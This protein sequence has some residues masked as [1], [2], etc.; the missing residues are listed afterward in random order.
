MQPCSSFGQPSSTPRGR[1]FL[2]LP[3]KT[4]LQHW[5][6][7]SNLGCSETESR[8]LHTPPTL[9]RASCWV[10]T[11]VQHITSCVKLSKL[12]NFS[13]SQFHPF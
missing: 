2:C 7:I 10:H 9:S 5:S 13:V 11:T 3:N 6:A 12:L 1:I 8:K 4:E